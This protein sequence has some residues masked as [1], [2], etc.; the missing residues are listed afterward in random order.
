MRP[1]VG[2]LPVVSA[3][4]QAC[5]QSIFVLQGRSFLL[6]LSLVPREATAKL[7]WLWV[8]GWPWA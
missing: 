5:L 2:V 3:P 1:R 6:L 7:H 4:P 8:T